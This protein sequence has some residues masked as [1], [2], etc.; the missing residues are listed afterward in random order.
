M[1][2]P[3]ITASSAELHFVIPWRTRKAALFLQG[4]AALW[5]GV[6]I[7]G[8]LLFAFYVADF[9]G[10]TAIQGDWKAWNKVLVAGHIPGD[11]AGNTVLAL[12]LLFAVVVMLSGAAQLVPVVRRHW[13]RVH[14]WNGRLFLISAMIASVGGVFMI[15]TRHIAG[16]QLVGRL[17]M[18]LDALLI[19]GFA[20]LAL[21]EAR[22]GRFG[23]HR[24]WAL[25]L[26]LAVSGV[27]FFRVGLMFWLAVNQAPVGFDPDTFT[28]PFLT[29]LGFAE[30]L[31]P[32]AVLELY[33]WSQKCQ[34]VPG[35]VAMA[36]ALTLL[37][38]MMAVGIVAAFAGLWLPHL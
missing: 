19:L 35:K 33:F 27:W 6:A 13:P 31:L 32:L 37:T 12:H 38:L 7:L 29:F 26:F 15:W 14:R 21:R 18:S 22:A 17:S 4:A 9:Y 30:Y 1:Y 20:S 3:V 2:R 8:Q 16:D 34:N 24:R 11:T 23:A 28:G 10:R 36:S 5:L 25:R